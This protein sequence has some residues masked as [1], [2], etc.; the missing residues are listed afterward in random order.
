MELIARYGSAR[1][2]PLVRV[3]IDATRPARS[4]PRRSRTCSSTIPR[5]PSGACSP[6]SIATARACAWFPPGRS[7]PRCTGTRPSR[8]RRSPTCRARVPASCRT[9]RRSSGRAGRREP[10]APPRAPRPLERGV[11][12]AAQSE[13]DALVAGPLAFD[14]PVV[15]ENALVDALLDGRAALADEGGDRARPRAVPDQ[16][17]PGQRRRPARS[18]PLAEP[19]GRLSRVQGSGST[20]PS[21]GDRGL[22]EDGR[23]TAAVTPRDVTFKT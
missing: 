4:R 6:G 12:S 23:A 11:A 13:L 20:K 19:G 22:R 17:L 5:P 3:E 15:V 1:L 14:S 7:S 18:R 10:R 9:P 16:G 2:L 21:P 8:P